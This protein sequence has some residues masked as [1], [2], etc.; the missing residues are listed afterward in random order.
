[1]LQKFRTRGIANIVYGILIIATV[2]VFVIQFGPQAGKKSA[3]CTRTCF[4]SVRGYCLDNKVIKA[5]VS[6]IARFGAE[7]QQRGSRAGEY[8]EHNA[9]AL[10]RDAIV[11]RELLVA[12]ADRLG[13]GVGKD[14]FNEQI[15]SGFARLSLPTD[16]EV[17]LA[18][19]TQMYSPFVVKLG[20]LFDAKGEFDI[21]N[22]K[23]KVWHAV[24]LSEADFRE[25]QTREI[26]AAK[27]KD[28]IRASVRVGE[29]EAY[30]LWFADQDTADL[31]YAVVRESFVRRWALSL[32]PDDIEKWAKSHQKDIDE[33][34]E[35]QKDKDFPKEK[36]IRHI[37]AS[38]RE[39][40]GPLAET[41][42]QKAFARA[43]AS[44]IYARIKYGHESFAEVAR[45]V[46]DDPGSAAKGGSYEESETTGFEQ[47]FKNAME[48][49][50]PGQMTEGLVR[51]PF[52]YHIIMKDDP[53]K[54]PDEAAMKR[55]IA[56][57]LY[58]EQV[59][60]PEEK[61]REM[62]Q[63]LLEAW[64][65]GKTADDAIKDIFGALRST[66]APATLL[67]ILDESGALP[68]A[69]DAGAVPAADASAAHGPAVDAGA[70]P[71]GT[72]AGVYVPE[73]DWENP[74][75][76]I[77][78]TGALSRASNGVEFLGTAA[79]QTLI[80]FA[81]KAKEKDVLPTSLETTSHGFAVFRLKERHVPTRDEFAKAEI[82]ESEHPYPP[83]LLR[84]TRE[85]KEAEA[86][87]IYMKQL[88]DAAKK[89]D[90]I[91]LAPVAD[92][93]AKPSN[94]GPLDDP[95]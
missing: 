57:L 75:F 30:A 60:K 93:G 77:G 82:K 24:E 48:K 74:K 89:E 94:E 68:S 13:I 32:N 10:V 49:L 73:N 61:V 3:S 20:E 25:E 92:G 4:A 79:D 80:D 42:E 31:E 45:E 27:M 21:K 87:L 36:R 1:M 66:A 81:F 55:G 85:E 5:E 23:T 41:E 47:S 9:G 14:E 44:V 35:K 46:S 90:A 29:P 19:G 6:L 86:L 67:P 37:L 69:A 64:K 38:F 12:E 17:K 83:G 26:L 40:P 22:Y 54:Q 16:L 95:Q 76:S 50:Q 59:A 91:K 7:L 28:M 15:H 78:T 43:R 62:T 51:T 84:S 88:Q 53:S 63:K 39:K 52:G 8:I 33:A 65:A 11:E 56:R 70:V 2:L 72:S 18:Y 71:A 58:I 34:F